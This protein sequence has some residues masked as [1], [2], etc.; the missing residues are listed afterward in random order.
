MK[1]GRF[2]LVGIFASAIP[3]AYGEEAQ[4][5]D[6][7]VYDDRIEFG[8]SAAFT[9][10]AQELGIN[11]NIGIQVAFDEV[12][13]RGGVHGR[14]F[15][16][17][18]LDDQYEPGLAAENTQQLISDHHVFALIGEVG[19]PTSKAALPV[20]LRSQVPFIGPFTGAPFLREA[21]A[22]DWVINFRASYFEETEK[23]VEFLTEDL[24]VNR[25][26]MVYQDDSFGQVGYQGI[27]NAM[28]RRNMNLVGTGIYARNT[29]AVK[30]AL[31]DVEYG[32][33][34][35]IVIIGAYR[36]TAELIMWA[37]YIGM[38]PTFIT[39]SFV[40]SNALANQLGDR[41]LGVYVTQVVPL[42]TAQDLKLTQS[43]HKALEEYTDGV[44]P[45]FI[46]YEGYIIG[47]LTIELMERTGANP[48]REALM[49]TMRSTTEMTI[50]DFTLT[51]SPEDNQG[52]NSVFITK[53]GAGK[54]YLNVE[55]N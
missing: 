36:P 21:E 54:R 23:M 34:E 41:G 31:L 37:R 38:N 40:G 3:S 33:P 49:N 11:L 1:F 5:N 28:A 16:L 29:V 25:I 50:D 51:Y 17:V 6:P 55:R 7:G 52:S 18:K 43:Y 20:I 13:A 27:L 42:P 35:A 24:G 32:K 26:G 8:Q 45:G 9:G 47:R 19:T 48:T 10:P 30:T 15:D 22:H 46:S 4:P 39:L 12:N 14:R 44:T 53:I 2:L